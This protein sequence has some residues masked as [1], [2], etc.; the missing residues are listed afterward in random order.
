ME[1]EDDAQL[2]C[3][4]LS[5]DDEAFNTLVQKYQKSVH[6]FV[7]RKIEDFHYA[8]EI[9]QDTFLQAHKKLSTLRDPN[10]FAGWVYIIANRLCIA[11]MRKQKPA[12]QSLSDTSVKEIDN[13][14][15]ERYV[16]EQRES[17]ATAHRY[18]IVENLLKKL[19]ESERTVMTLYY[20]GEMTIK[21][22]GK[23]LGVSVNTIT[24]RLHRARRR[25]Q[26]DQDTLIVDL[27]TYHSRWRRIVETFSEADAKKKILPEIESLLREHPET[28]ELLN[29]V[30]WGY[31]EL[32]DRAKNVPNSLFDKMLRYP[33]TENYLTA[34]LGLAER[35]EDA[36]QQW[37]YYQRVIDE[38]TVSDAPILSW[39][40]LAYEQLLRLAEVDRSLV[41]EDD[42]DELI[43][44][45]LKAHLS[46]CKETQ[47][48][49]GWA[50]TAAVKYRL[51]FNNRLDKAL[52]TLERAEIRLG[53]EE[54]QKWLVENNKGSVED[55]RKNLSRLRCE[56]YIRQE[57][58]REAHDG[59]VANA[60]GC[61][62][63][64]WAR[65]NEGTINYFYMLGRS[66]EGLGD[67]EKARRYYADAYFA[68]IPHCEKVRHYYDFA[69][70]HFVATPRVESR[71]G[72]ERL[73][74]EIK[75]G[76]TTDT[77][78]AFLKDT[79]AEYR[80]REAADH[81]TI[82]Q[83][84]ITN[85]LNKKAM[86]FRL[87]TLEG[88]TYTLSAMSGKI[89]LLAVGGSLYGGNM[90]IP[91]VE[92]VYERFSNVDD[93]VIW[94]ISDGE[95]PQ[96]VREFLE[97]YQPSWPLLLDPHR[98]VKKAYQIERI[99]AFILI[100]KA[101][102][103]QYSFIGLDLIGGQPLIWMIEAL[104]SD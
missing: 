55:E 78:E 96:K 77:L 5:G 8:E 1:R 101:G 60:L 28:P 39:Y 38:F 20:L 89:V 53:E 7:W 102:N 50:Y 69:D 16:S 22:I 51:K 83:K 100:D 42:L 87:E 98:Q 76:E 64:L 103:W 33:K 24:S 47:Q 37:Y 79:E 12:M 97:Q 34:L 63:S 61:L 75:R 25:L 66:A 27:K 74:R 17:E 2:I 72:L 44:G 48:W 23:S 19:P 80:I 36:S 56:I 3:K 35:S 57:R 49:F 14:T 85:K 46:Y 68:P 95:A 15:Y 94:D 31:M 67:Y 32:P 90:V 65:F 9:T 10:Q 26:T 62:E 13:L 4:V 18:E 99:P 21:E 41:K 86:D 84:L 11:W 52:E 59:L 81:E 43:E 91:E 40:W 54:E 70:T 88:E 30:Y 71:K 58:W 6:A 29:T 45:C 73:Y 82:R 104:L 93:V 92:L